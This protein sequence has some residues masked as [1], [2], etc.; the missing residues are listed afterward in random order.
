[1]FADKSQKLINQILSIEDLTGQ[2]KTI[3]RKTKNKALGPL[4]SSAVPCS[5]F[6]V[7]DN[8]NFDNIGIGIGSCHGFSGLVK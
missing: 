6:I 2:P 4:C 5:A 8:C 1:M 7:Y 3:F